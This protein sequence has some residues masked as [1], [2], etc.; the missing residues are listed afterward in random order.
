MDEKSVSMAIFT[1]FGL[2]AAFAY[3]Y[4]YPTTLLFGVESQ[5]PISLL[6]IINFLFGAIFFGY[7]AFIPALL[8]G[9]QLGAQKNAAIFLYIFP[10]LIS[11][12]AGVKLG[13]ALESDFW[14]KKNY[15]NVIKIITTIL[16]ISLVIAVLIELI[17]PFLV[18]F[19]PADTGLTVQ[20][21]QTVMG[22]LNELNQF[23]R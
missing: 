3:S 13:F 9:L 8:I 15:L 6:T 14:G 16:V 21:S 4:F 5:I 10:L 7:A 23:K 20:E 22:L 1:L 11:T 12:Y 2:L 19:W 17:L 18:Q